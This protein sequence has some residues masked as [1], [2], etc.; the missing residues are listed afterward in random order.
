MSSSELSSFCCSFIIFIREEVKFNWLFQKILKNG[1]LFG[2]RNDGLLGEGKMELE[3]GSLNRWIGK[4][5]CLLGFRL[6]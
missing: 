5:S 6:K 2:K 4:I 1:I 3:E